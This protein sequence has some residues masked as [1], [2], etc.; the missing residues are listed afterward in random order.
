LTL[1][2]RQVVVVLEEAPESVESISKGSKDGFSHIVT[3]STHEDLGFNLALCFPTPN[4]VL[5]GKGKSI[6][7]IMVHNRDEPEHPAIRRVL[8]AAIETGTSAGG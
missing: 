4:G 3:Y 8:Q 7:H 2:L 5:T 6:R 1:A